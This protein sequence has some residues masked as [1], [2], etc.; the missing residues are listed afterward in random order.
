MIKKIKHKI[1]NSI[2]SKRINVF[3][4]FLVLSFMFLLLTKLTK[5]Y[6][7]TIEFAISPINATENHVILNDSSHKLDITLSTYGF[8]LM[9]YYLTRPILTVD[10]ND[11]DNQNK[12]YVWTNSKGIAHI[13][14]Q[15]SENVKI[16]AVNPDSLIFR[17]DINEI[18][19]IPVKLI[20]E[21]TFKPG[22]DILDDFTIQPD[23]IKLI[24]PK[25][26]LDSIDIIETNV[27]SLNEVNKDIDLSLS[28]ILP[29]SSQNIT[30]SH[31]EVKVNGKVEKF[32]EGTI[33]VPIDV[34]NVP[35]N[36]KI[37]YFPKT[38]NV[39]YYTSLSSFK[40]VSGSDFI[41]ECD[42]RELNEE[43]T[44]LEPKLVKLPKK[45]KNVKLAQKKIEFIISK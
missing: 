43:K 20:S 2:K 25:I 7:K 40:Q 41:V 23:S 38:T 13:N 21:L 16:M 30:Y 11:L 12:Q 28:I 14:N 5:D 27:L 6:T 1:S 33:E 15:F 4:L 10:L 8:K 44:A 24:G 9:R 36:V 19:K 35:K 29:D 39:M 3:L 31:K 37:N 34:I 18:K 32:T 45:V 22:Y 17:Y 26:L 42:Y